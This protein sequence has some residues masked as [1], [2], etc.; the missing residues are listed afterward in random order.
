MAKS[1]F[2]FV[3]HPISGDVEGNIQKVLKICR[4]IHSLNVIPLFPRYLNKSYLSESERDVELVRETVRQH[5]ERRVVDELWLYGDR[6]SQG[7]WDEIVLARQNNVPVIAKSPET[8]KELL[9]F[10]KGSSST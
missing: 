3:A 10:M 4:R 5:F 6:I 9:A 8:A 1:K 2:V 7:M